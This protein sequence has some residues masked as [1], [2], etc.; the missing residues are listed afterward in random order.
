MKN[1]YIDIFEDKLGGRRA[2]YGISLDK[3]QIDTK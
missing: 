3:I 2:S 1:V